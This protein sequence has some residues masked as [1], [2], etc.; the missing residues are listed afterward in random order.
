[1][2][3]LRRLFGGERLSSDFVIIIPVGIL[4]VILIVVVIIIVH[5]YNALFA[6]DS[7]KVPLHDYR[8]PQNLAP[9]CIL[10]HTV[11]W[12]T[13]LLT[14]LRLMHCGAVTAYARIRTERNSCAHSTKAARHMNTAQNSRTA[15]SKTSTTLEPP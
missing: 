13:M 6:T 8:V 11:L 15:L 14:I 9:C 5:L 10:F 1:V 7:A 2:A 12:Q 4:L 3:R